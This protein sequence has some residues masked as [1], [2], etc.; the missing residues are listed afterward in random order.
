MFADH[1]SI[2]FSA[3]NLSELQNQMNPKLG[4][5]HRWLKTNKLNLNVA[6]TEFM[7]I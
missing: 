1:T 6:K 7:I 5:L 4:N 2:S 3:R